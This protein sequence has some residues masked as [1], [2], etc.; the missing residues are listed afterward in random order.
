MKGAVPVIRRICF[1]S[2]ASLY[3]GFCASRGLGDAYAGFGKSPAPF[4]TR[5]P[6]TLSEATSAKR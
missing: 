5:Q 2:D 4:V 3:Q 1:P 6:V